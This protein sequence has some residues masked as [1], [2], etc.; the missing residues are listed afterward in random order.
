VRIYLDGSSISTT[1]YRGL[2]VSSDR[3]LEK[4]QRLL[5]LYIRKY[6]SKIKTRLLNSHIFWDMT[7]FRPV[8]M[9]HSFGG[10]Y[11]LRIQDNPTAVFRCQHNSPVLGVPL[12]VVWTVDIRGFSSTQPYFS[13][14][15]FI[16]NVLV[17]FILGSDLDQMAG[18][19][20]W[21]FV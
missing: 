20:N 13:Y 19:A 11:F 15:L 8:Y 14:S 12:S 2:K 6:T 10:T 17:Y 16:Y 18:H 3:S 7:P 1:Q 21:D 4:V 9:Y 5:L